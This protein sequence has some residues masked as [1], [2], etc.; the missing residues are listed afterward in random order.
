MVPRYCTTAVGRYGVDV[1][2]ASSLTV[3]ASGEGVLPRGGTRVKKRH[4]HAQMS[5]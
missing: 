2:V 4:V 1:A 3:C 5:T